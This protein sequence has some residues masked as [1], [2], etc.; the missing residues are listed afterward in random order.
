MYHCTE[1]GHNHAHSTDKCYILKNREEKASGTSSLG[2]TKKSPFRKEINF[3]A[4]GKPRKKILEMFFQLFSTKSI[5]NF[6]LQRPL[7]TK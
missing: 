3:L 7:K 2:L 5:R 1:H 6:T 4:K